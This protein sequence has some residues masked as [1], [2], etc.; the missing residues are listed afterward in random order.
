[1]TKALHS[2][3]KQQNLLKLLEQDK[4]TLENEI[5]GYRQEAQKQRKIIQQ[6][7]KERDR[8]VN[9]SSGLMQKAGHADGRIRTSSHPLYYRDVSVCF[10]FDFLQVQQKITAVEGKEMEIFDLRKKVT[11][12][13]AKVKQQ[14]NQLESVVTERNLY[15]RN[16]IECQVGGRSWTLTL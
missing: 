11:E 15:S 12:S 3:E 14:E 9:E 2:A 6:L 16:L 13:E 4:R 8:Y 1:M 10:A 5:S 7:E